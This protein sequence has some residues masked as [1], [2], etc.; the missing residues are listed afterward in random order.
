MRYLILIKFRLL[1]N[2]NLIR[3][4]FISFLSDK[5]VGKVGFDDKKNY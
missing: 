5:I 2:R 1:L 3:F 4:I